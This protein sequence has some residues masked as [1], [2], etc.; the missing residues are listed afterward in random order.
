MCDAGGFLDD[1]LYSHAELQHY[2]NLPDLHSVQAQTVGILSMALS[3]TTGLLS[4]HQRLLTLSLD[5]LA[6]GRDDSPSSETPS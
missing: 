1:R 4:H 2:A 3:R 6:A 5:A